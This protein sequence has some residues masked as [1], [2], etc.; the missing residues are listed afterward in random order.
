MTPLRRADWAIAAVLAAAVLVLTQARPDVPRLSGQ[1][2]DDGIYVITAKALAEGRGYRLTHLPA[3]PPQTKYPPLYPAALAALWRF[4]PHFPGNVRLLEWVGVLGAAAAAAGGYVY[5][6]RYGYAGRLV[7][8]ASLAAVVTSP[9]YLLLAT[10]L[11]AEMPFAALLLF[12]LWRLERALADPARRPG[13]WLGVALALP[14]LCRMPGVVLPPVGLLLLLRT[15]CRPWRTALG[16][17]VVLAPWAAW[18]ATAAGSYH[19]DPVTGYY[20]DYVGWWS[21]IGPETLVRVASHNLIWVLQATGDQPA[22][23][24]AALAGPGAT[25]VVA[26]ALGLVAWAGVARDAWAGRPA[27]WF[28]V[29]Y[30][31]LVL[32]W[33]WP[34]ARF[35]TPALPLLA[36]Y[37]FRPLARLPGSRWLVPALAV[38]LAGANMAVVSQRWEHFRAKGYEPA[39]IFPNDPDWAAYQRYF[40]WVQENTPPDAVVA[41]QA[42]PVVHLYTGRKAFNPFVVDPARLFYG[43]PGEALPAAA[44][45]AARLRDG[46][47]GFVATIPGVEGDPLLARYEQLV[48]DGVLTRVYSDPV[49][50]GLV[51]YRVNP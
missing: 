10:L 51:V 29:A 41:S 31:G 4:A 5:A 2:H 17:A 38:A 13:F 11:L 30:L 44:D 46:R 45:L 19:A 9:V 42:D 26:A 20:L 15:G 22:A 16:V 27:A 49:G 28:L 7:A 39:M 36:V 35:V 3:E 34:P 14:A 40:G 43:R 33:P 23:G 32:V 1:F 47:A 8:A 18:S 50:R 6:V 24:L 12:A 37:L 25:A 48:V 21:A